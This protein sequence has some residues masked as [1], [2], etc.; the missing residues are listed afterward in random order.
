MRKQ[1]EATQLKYA[2]RDIRNLNTTVRLLESELEGRRR[3]GSIMSNIA[4]NLSR[5]ESTPPEL[6]ATLDEC[7]KG[8]DAIRTVRP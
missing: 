8:W 6:R 5:K 2:K 1:S 3:F 4:Y 7:R